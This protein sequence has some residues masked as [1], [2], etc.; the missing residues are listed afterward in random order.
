MISLVEKPR[1]ISLDR[2]FGPYGEGKTDDKPSLHKRNGIYY[3]SWSSYYAMSDNIYGPYVYKGV[4]ITPESTA[5]EFHFE[6][7]TH[8]RHGNFFSWY[9][10]W[11]YICNDKS[12]PGRSEYF[13]D[14]VIGY[15]H[16]R[17]NGEMAPVRLDR[18]GVG[19][20]DGQARIEAANYFQVQNAEQQ[21]S[22]TGGFEVCGL[23]NGSGLLYPNVHYIPANGTISFHA[24]SANASGGVIEVR[25]NDPDGALLGTCKVPGTSGWDKFETFSCALQTGSGTRNIYLAV[26]GGD[27]ELLHLDWFQ[28]A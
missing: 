17:R 28:F 5:P 16:F 11:Y 25:E 23:R 18:I 10:Q 7:L 8:D 6:N 19:Q 1:P 3:L 4:V 27:G 9:D 24:S 15:V 22:P 21:E 2:K 12:Q 26:K 20:Y 14:S 13:R